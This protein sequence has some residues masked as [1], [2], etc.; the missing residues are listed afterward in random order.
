MFKKN[1]GNCRFS[2]KHEKRS[3]TDLDTQNGFDLGL[4]HEKKQPA[5]RKQSRRLL[6]T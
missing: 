1:V 6:G 3:V 4:G 2:V 5:S